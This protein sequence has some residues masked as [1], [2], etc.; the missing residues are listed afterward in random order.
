MVINFL[1]LAIFIMIYLLWTCGDMCLDKKYGQYS[2]HFEILSM[3]RSSLLADAF[4]VV[5]GSGPRRPPKFGHRPA[6]LELLQTRS[7]RI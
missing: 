1:H 6:F 4:P 3:L 5:V 2:Q 7:E